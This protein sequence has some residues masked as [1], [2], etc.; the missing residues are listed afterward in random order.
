MSRPIFASTPRWKDTLT[1][2]ADA[3]IFSPGPRSKRRQKPPEGS[4]DELLPWLFLQA[5]DQLEFAR[6]ESSTGE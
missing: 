6:L 3:A 5:D 2:R 4:G 1:F